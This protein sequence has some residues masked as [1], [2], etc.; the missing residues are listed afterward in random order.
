M[1]SRKISNTVTHVSIRIIV[2]CTSRKIWRKTII[3]VVLKQHPQQKPVSS[4]L[5]QK[6]DCLLKDF[7]LTE[8]K[9]KCWQMYVIMYICTVVI[10]NYFYPFFLNTT[11]FIVTASLQVARLLIII[12]QH[13]SQ[14][15]LFLHISPGGQYEWWPCM[16]HN[17]Q[18]HWCN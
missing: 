10:T 9:M 8:P 1:K 16:S 15:L 14:Q 4:F 7:W 17:I 18:Y 2:I 13:V 6:S 12:L 11:L 3:E 5:A